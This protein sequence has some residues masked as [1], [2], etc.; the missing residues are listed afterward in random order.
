MAG[1]NRLLSYAAVVC[2]GLPV[3]A[4]GAEP[5]AN[6]AALGKSLRDPSAAVRLRAALALGESNDAEA[7]PV[8]IEL[9]GELPRR[10]RQ[11]VE[12]FLTRLAGEWSPLVQFPT[13]DEIGRRI[14]R[15][16][17]LAW[18]RN[19]D[20]EALLALLRKH[21]PTDD[22]R[23]KVR[24]LLSEFK[25]RKYAVQK[26]AAEELFALGR[27]ALPQLRA[28]VEDDNAELS[29]RLLT[30]IERIERE[31]SHRLPSV[32]VRL[33]AV[34]K[35]AGAV[36]ALL[37]YLPFVEEETQS[38]EVQKSLASLAQRDGKLDPALVR[39]LSASQPSV[40]ATVA[41]AL[42]RGGGAPG[43]AAVRKLLAEDAPM[44]R[45]RIALAL[46]V[47]HEREGVSTL[48]DLLTVLPGEMVG[49]VEDALYQLAGESA[50]DVSLGLEPGQ[51]KKCRDA[52]A[53]W[54]KLNAE[55]VDLARLTTRPSLG[56][57]L[58]CDPGSNRIYEVDRRGKMRWSIDNVGGPVDA[59]MVRGERVLVAEA[60]NQAVSERDVGGKVLW[61]KAVGRNALSVQPLPNGNV[62]IA[63]DNQVLEVT[64]AG[65]EVYAVNHLGGIVWDAYRTRSGNIVCLL[66][67]GQCLIVDTTGK[68]LKRFTAK[69]AGPSGSL[70]VLAND[71]LLVAQPQ[72]NKVVEYN[73]DGK[74]LWEGDAPG[75]STAT[76][77]ANGHILVASQSAHRVYEIDRAGK[78]V[79]EQKDTG[80]AF[81][82]RRR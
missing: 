52:W 82:A 1:M 22:D 16:A 75:V 40:R 56:F 49:Q 13:E 50:P 53:A 11:P 32:A 27:V 78:I 79:W 47:A 31:P 38:S 72:R 70:D 46:A 34:R 45:M 2:L 25:D 51:K 67:S 18:W 59:W 8:L 74:K 10:K 55:R 60:A 76:G 12:E 6:R 20:G 35:P 62:F 71:R 14:R 43:R 69:E 54:W 5:T 28:A 37:A 44:V 36:E 30:L 81:R 42:V 77:L 41:E 73:S 65:K 61:R 19:T 64:R 33:L 9:L 7:I 68:Q 57:T 63:L 48:I 23:D 15:D 80:M 24:R 29:R 58:I 21:T 26:G 4:V 17:W 3:T 39:A 66:N